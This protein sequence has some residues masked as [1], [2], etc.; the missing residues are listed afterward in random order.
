MER[1][2]SSAQHDDLRIGR[3]DMRLFTA[4]NPLC[5]IGY[6]LVKIARRKGYTQY[7]CNRFGQ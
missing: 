4:L 3:D 7:M 6:R 1:L 2:I 5:Q